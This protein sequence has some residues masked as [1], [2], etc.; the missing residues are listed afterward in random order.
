[1][2]IFELV[3]LLLMSG[4]SMELVTFVQLFLFSYLIVMFVV[5]F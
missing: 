2:R 3:V 4:S 5:L 1:M